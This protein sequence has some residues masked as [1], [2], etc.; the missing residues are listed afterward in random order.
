MQLCSQ[1]LMAGAASGLA[2]PEL[3]HAERN[4]NTENI[5]MRRTIPTDSAVFM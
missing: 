4:S 2:L 5:R 3:P 1:A